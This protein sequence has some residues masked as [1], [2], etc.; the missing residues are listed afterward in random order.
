MEWNQLLSQK[1]FSV[2][3]KE[4][5][6]FDD[7]V[8]ISCTGRNVKIIENFKNLA[9]VNDDDEEGVEE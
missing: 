1:S 8:E 9:I 7:D 4:V 5:V 2:F 3:F 6:E